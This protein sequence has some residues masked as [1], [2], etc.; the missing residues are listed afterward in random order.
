MHR[1]NLAAL[2]LVMTNLVLPSA[3]G[4]MIDFKPVALETK[5]SDRLI[6]KGYDGDVKF[7]VTK[8]SQLV[9]RVRQETSD[10]SAAL[11]KQSLDEWNFSVQRVEGGIEMV[12]QS[13]HA[14]EVWRHLLMNGGG[15][16]FHLEI[17]AP[18][19]PLEVVW[20]HGKIQ[21]D[22]WSAPIR[23]QALEGSIVIN[24]GNGDVKA[25]LQEG[26]LR[27]K[28]RQGKVVAENFSG[29]LLLDDIKGNVETELFVGDGVLNGLEGNIEL[30]SHKASVVV[31]GGKGRFDF[32]STRGSIKLTQFSG[33]LK[34]VTE[35]GQIN[36][37]IL[38]A[39]DVRITAQAGSVNLELPGSG[40]SVSVSS[41]E[42]SISG[43]S[44]LKTDQLAGQRVMR[45]R[46]R[47]S[48]EGSV[49][50]RTTTGSVRIR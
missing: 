43:P 25:T 35:E 42:G 47:G 39:G 48:D 20:R 21:I 11:I 8:G 49:V 16:K 9:V 10:Q 22:S 46:L 37:K 7:I 41:T 33:D 36:A 28:K 13:P 32:D 50:V 18:A 27:I 15:P 4:A 19:L 38:N 40:A 1:S 34:G 44:H 5:P 14:K 17:A 29:K 45:G 23:A 2:I 24:G 12:V 6:L 3:E 26:D 31:T 30:H